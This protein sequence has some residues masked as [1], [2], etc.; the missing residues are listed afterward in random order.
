[1]KLAIAT[2]GRMVSSDNKSCKEITIAEIVEG[3]LVEIIKAKIDVQN[4]ESFGL[5]LKEFGI[6]VFI[7]GIMEIKMQ[8]HLEELDFIVIPNIEGDIQLAIKDFMLGRLT[9]EA[10]S[11][12]SGC[13]N[14]QCGNKG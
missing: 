8:N 1:M 5:A 9:S 7:T 13:E 2:E 12:S 4:E 10:D 14:C 3:E 11:C 6:D